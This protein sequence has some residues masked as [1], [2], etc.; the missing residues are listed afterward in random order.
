[1]LSQYQCLPRVGHLNAI[2]RIFKYLKNA[3]QAR[4]MFDPGHIDLTSVDFGI[5]ELGKWKEF[6]PDA[7]E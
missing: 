4:I 7:E 5:S 3:D 1:M 6:Y 2:Y